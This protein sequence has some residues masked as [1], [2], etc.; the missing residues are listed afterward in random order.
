MAGEGGAH[1][2]PEHSP[3]VNEV[4]KIRLKILKEAGSNF[5]KEIRRLTSAAS[6]AA[7]EQAK[8]EAGASWGESGGGLGPP[9]GG[10]RVDRCR[11]PLRSI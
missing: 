4:E 8:K 7:A 2:M 1:Q 5:A 10:G 3:A 9:S 6:A 11:F